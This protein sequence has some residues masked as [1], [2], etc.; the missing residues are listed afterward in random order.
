[1]M[2]SLFGLILLLRLPLCP[3]SRDYLEV[4]RYP[5]TYNSMPTS[6]DLKYASHDVADMNSK[7]DHIMDHQCCLS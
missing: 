5:R 3:R 2:K 6:A 7:S 1:M 4:T